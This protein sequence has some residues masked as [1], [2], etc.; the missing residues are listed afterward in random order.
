MFW[1]QRLRGLVFDW[2]V[3]V[4]R[5]HSYKLEP[6]RFLFWLLVICSL[7]SRWR[8]VT[9]SPGSLHCC[10]HNLTYTVSMF[11]V[12]TSSFA[13]ARS[14]NCTVLVSLSFCDL[15]PM[16][17]GWGSMSAERWEHSGKWLLPDRLHPARLG[18]G[19]EVFAR[20]CVL[21]LFFHYQG[22]CKLVCYCGKQAINCL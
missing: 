8:H 11:T 21:L 13:T 5:A 7:Y 15:W 4:M 20:V 16:N 2:L 3:V 6:Y 19:S 17:Q 22:I 12:L 10:F 18:N 9:W 14:L 1:K